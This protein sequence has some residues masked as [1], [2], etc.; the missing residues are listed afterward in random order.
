MCVVFC[1]IGHYLPDIG[2]GSF[3]I[4]ARARN[5]G[6]PGRVVSMTRAITAVISP[7]YIL[8]NLVVM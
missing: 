2:R 8:I 6:A 5:A 3:V 7:F 4:R 1:Q